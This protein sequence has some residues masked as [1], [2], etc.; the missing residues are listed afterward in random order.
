MEEEVDQLREVAAV[1][2]ARLARS[3]DATT[4]VDVLNELARES[5]VQGERAAYEHAAK[6]LG[7]ALDHARCAGP[8]NTRE[9]RCAK[10]CCT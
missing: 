2:A 7:R 10:W 4:H 3:C 9:R 8:A 6:M 1:L 5:T